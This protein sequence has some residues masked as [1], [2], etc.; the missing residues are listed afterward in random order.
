M[1]GTALAIANF[2]SSDGGVKERRSRPIKHRSAASHFY[3]M[4]T[5][6]TTQYCLGAPAPAPDAGD[7]GS[8]VVVVSERP[9]LYSSLASWWPLVSAPEEYAEEAAIY[10]RLL[11]ASAERPIESVLELGS[12]GGNN[13]FH[14]KKHWRMTL[15][16][17]SDDMLSV[18]RRLNPECVHVQGDMRTVRLNETFDA[19]FIHDA[20]DYMT[21][22][23]DLKSAMSTAYVHCREGGAALFA[24]DHVAESFT[25]STDHGGHDGDGRGVRYLEWTWDPDPTDSTGITDYVFVFRDNDGSVTVEHDQHVWGLW[26]ISSWLRLLSEVGFVARIE[27][28][29]HS[30]L[31]EPGHIFAATR[32]GRSSDVP[33]R[34]QQNS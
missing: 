21:T 15:T 32:P 4:E 30:E 10:R 6:S 20:I 26:P 28:F 8:R 9:K 22:E 18:S 2:V 16:D 23:D 34:T 11:E 25:S 1:I 17:S 12:G 29:D 7:L 33:D 27:R 14:L 5:A 31:D 19:V 13:A 3:L 24:P